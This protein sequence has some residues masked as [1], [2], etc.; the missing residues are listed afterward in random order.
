VVASLVIAAV[1][2]FAAGSHTFASLTSFGGLESWASPSHL[3]GR[4][5]QALAGQFAGSAVSAGLA[6][7]LE[8]AFLALFVILLWRLMRDADGTDA[9]G[10][11]GVALLLLAL[12]LPY[13]LPWYA[14]W[15]A[16]FLGIFADNA[17][18]LVGVFVTA[19]LALA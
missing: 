5:A 18:V 9:A 1:A 6:K 13:L 8:G 19:V 10:T 15:F 7:A 12:S 4:G 2:P 17:F 11:W 14:A 16:P 3:V